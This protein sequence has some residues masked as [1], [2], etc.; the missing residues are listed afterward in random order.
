MNLKRLTRRNR[1][2]D[3]KFEDNAI[4]ENSVKDLMSFL[5]KNLKEID[6]KAAETW[7]VDEIESGDLDNDEFK[8][9]L[10]SFIIHNFTQS[11]KIDIIK[12]SGL[13]FG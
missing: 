8:D 10:C 7:F 2:S 12:E 3:T 5:F 11:D 6:W 9:R 4:H 1:I 13:K